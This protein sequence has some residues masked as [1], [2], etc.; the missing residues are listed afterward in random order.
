ML[1]YNLLL[2]ETH[3]IH[4]GIDFGAKMAGTTAI[5]F[6]TEG[7]IYIMQSQ[8]N[9]DA[10][11]FIEDAIHQY[12]PERIF[13][14]APLSLPMIYSNSGKGVDYFY[15]QCDKLVNAMSPMYLGGLTAR[16]MKLA[17]GWRRNNMSV[18]ESYPKKVKQL[19]LPGDDI[20]KES[21]DKIGN[22]M[23]TLN[24]FIKPYKVDLMPQNWHQVD[25]FYVG[26]LG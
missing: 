16:A 4:F 11:K 13:L 23:K 1:S 7:R 22:L 5:A 18:F 26:S 17:A 3:M 14:D 2:Y 20:Y 15:R 24:P 12:K 19:L 10:E 25:A 9:R 6:N 21:K 8:K